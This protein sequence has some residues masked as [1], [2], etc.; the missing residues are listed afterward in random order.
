MEKYSSCGTVELEELVRPEHLEHLE[1]L[2]AAHEDV[3]QC[4]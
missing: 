4:S 1:H 2:E 3:R